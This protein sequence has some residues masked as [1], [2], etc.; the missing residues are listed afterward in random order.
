MRNEV[1]H[2]PNAKTG[3]SSAEDGGF[4][5][6]TSVFGGAFEKAEP[7][8]AKTENWGLNLPPAS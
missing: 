7:G 3:A 8:L 5:V 4:G 2:A 1:G 6:A